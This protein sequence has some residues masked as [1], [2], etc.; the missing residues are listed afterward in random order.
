MNILSYLT[1]KS[2][3][4]FLDNN[5]TVRQALEKFDIHKFSIVPLIDENGKFVSTISEGDLL[6]FIKSNCNFD[7]K[8]AENTRISAIEKYRPYKALKISTPKEEIIR[9]S[10]EQN[11]VPIIDDRGAYIGIIKRKTIIDHLFNS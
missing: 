10:L 2:A 3:T 9:L 4:F 6:R 7:I 5:A 1:P 11:F 8:M